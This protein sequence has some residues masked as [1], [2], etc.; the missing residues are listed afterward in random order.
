MPK[1]VALSQE[2][3][4]LKLTYATLIY[5][6]WSHCSLL[7]FCPSEILHMNNFVCFCSILKS[8]EKMCLL[9]TVVV[10]LTEKYFFE[11]R[12]H[13]KNCQGSSETSK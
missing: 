7:C 3:Q 6:G 12:E 8:Y 4:F 1:R 5:L 10:K 13:S 11:A 9:H 2:G